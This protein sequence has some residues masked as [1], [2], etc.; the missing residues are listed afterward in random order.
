MEALMLTLG[1]AGIVAPLEYEP[2]GKL[3]GHRL[4]D[5]EPGPEPDQRDL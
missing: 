2:S 5:G 3:R 4:A 1:W